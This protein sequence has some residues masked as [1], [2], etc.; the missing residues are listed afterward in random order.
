MGGVAVVV[1]VVRKRRRARARA[2]ARRGG[3]VNASY[4]SNENLLFKAHTF[5]LFWVYVVY[6]HINN[7]PPRLNQLI[8][9]EAGS[10]FSVECTETLGIGRA[11]HT[12]RLAPEPIEARAQAAPTVAQT[13]VTA[14]GIF[15]GTL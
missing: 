14:F 1:A 12:T 15:R 13:T 2:S 11:V 10:R 3:A 6:P 7:N 8:N 9:H 4:E 5:L